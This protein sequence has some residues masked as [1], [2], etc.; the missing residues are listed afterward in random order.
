[1]VPLSAC[2]T[3]ADYEKLL[4]CWAD[5][6]DVD[7]VRNWGR[8]CKPMKRAAES[9]PLLLA[10]QRLRSGRGTDLPNESRR[11]HCVH[12]RNCRQPRNER[13]DGLRHD[14][15]VGELP[16]GLVVMERQ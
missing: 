12:R 1:M 16:S 2:A 15:R 10:A 7:L 9:S 14:V 6:Q 8:Q 5:A 4:N 11:E 13:Q 3:T